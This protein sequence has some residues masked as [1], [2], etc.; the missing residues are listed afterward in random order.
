[1][2]IIFHIFLKE[3]EGPN[4]LSRD[5]EDIKK[6]LEMKTTISEVIKYTGC[7]LMAS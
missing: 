6:L 4:T 3:L 1:M 7:K 2:I 5:I